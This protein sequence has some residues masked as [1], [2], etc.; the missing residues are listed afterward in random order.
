MK[1]SL[2]LA[3]S[4]DNPLRPNR[5]CGFIF[6]QV[7]T[8]VYLAIP[9]FHSICIP[10]SLLSL[11]LLEEQTGCT[12]VGNNVSSYGLFCVL[13]KLDFIQA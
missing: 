3:V 7:R 12:C 8:V 5:E 2:H 10:D 4:V 6:S 1:Q 11:P 9:H 13:H